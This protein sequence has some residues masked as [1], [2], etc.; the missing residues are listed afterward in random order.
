ML[1]VNVGG[2]LLRANTRN[3]HVTPSL[4]SVTPNSITLSIEIFFSPPSWTSKYASKVVPSTFQN[5]VPPMSCR[6]NAISVSR[7]FTH[8]VII[9]FRIYRDVHRVQCFYY[10]VLQNISKVITCFI[11]DS[12]T[13]LQMALQRQWQKRVSLRQ[14]YGGGG[15]VRY[16]SVTVVYLYR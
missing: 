7:T 8:M 6:H 3:M 11:Q 13:Q 2:E 10:S 5:K 9:V 4:Q 1:H 16:K 12:A 14:Q 15:V